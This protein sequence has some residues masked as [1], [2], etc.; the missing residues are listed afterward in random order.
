[1]QGKTMLQLYV[2]VSTPKYTTKRAMKTQARIRNPMYQGNGQNNINVSVKVLDLPPY[3][4]HL[5]SKQNS[6]PYQRGTPP[7]LQPNK[8]FMN[9]CTEKYTISN[10]T[11]K[12]KK[13][14]PQQDPNH[15][16][17]R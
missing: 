13:L 10:L 5:P 7:K 12:A 8:L 4:T 11:F 9:T 17:M 3:D 6:T 1:M 16:K 15:W 14:G 2:I